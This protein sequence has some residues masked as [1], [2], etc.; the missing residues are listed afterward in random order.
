MDRIITNKTNAPEFSE[1]QCTICT[2]PIFPAQSILTLACT[3]IFHRTCIAPWLVGHDQ[4]PNCRTEVT[5]EI[6]A[7]LRPPPREQ[8]GQPAEDFA[9]VRHHVRQ[10]LRE[11]DPFGPRGGIHRPPRDRLA[12][13]FLRLRFEQNTRI[14]NQLIQNFNP[15][16]LPLDNLPYIQLDALRAAGILEPA[17]APNNPLLQ[18]PTQIGNQINRFF[19]RFF[20]P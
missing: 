20:N 17:P 15:P 14:T 7:Q 12:E 18:L 4:C 13:D 3:H 11:R 2:D 10:L 16:I 6:L 9:R 1:P 5:P 8:S 19:Q